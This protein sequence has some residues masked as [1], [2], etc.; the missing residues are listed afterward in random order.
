M[1]GDVL[2]LFYTALKDLL[3]TRHLNA[4]SLMALLRHRY[5]GKRWASV[6]KWV[7]GSRIPPDEDT[8]YQIASALCASV[9][10]YRYLGQS[11]EYSVFLDQLR[12]RKLPAGGIDLKRIALVDRRMRRLT[13]RVTVEA[14][15]AE[16]ER[17]RAAGQAKL[18]W[19]RAEVVLSDCVHVFGRRLVRHP[20]AEVIADIAIDRARSKLDACLPGQA[21][22]LATSDD[23]L[24]KAVGEAQNLP[25]LLDLQRIVQ[26]EA[27][28]KDD[29][30]GGAAGAYEAIAAATED[31]NVKATA[32]SAQAL[33][34]AKRQG[35]G[36]RVAFEDV[37]VS[38]VVQVWSKERISRGHA[39]LGLFPAGDRLLTE[40]AV[41][42]EQARAL[43]PGM[44]VQ[45]ARTRFCCSACLRPGGRLT[46]LSSWVTTPEISPSEPTVHGSSWKPLLGRRR[47][48]TAA[49]VVV[50]DCLCRRYPRH[51]EA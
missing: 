9:P 3:D 49:S 31:A 10:E 22:G 51:S 25:R 17:L 4:T 47:C 12:G 2:P 46:T 43:T 41:Q 39:Y 6:E 38:A 34:Y 29:R 15:L 19:G 40:T 45:L 5:P 30:F 44:Q 36:D 21:V 32:L 16:I 11:Y 1:S 33:C 27:L 42:V 8:V 7:A 26:A 23:A 18:A 14:E 35:I 50:K 28:Y 37:A 13:S 48:C 20:A 24:V